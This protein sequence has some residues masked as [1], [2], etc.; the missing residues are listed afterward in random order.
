MRIGGS[1]ILALTLGDRVIHAALTEAR[2]G[3]RIVRKLARFEAPTPLLDRPEMTG[4]ALAQFLT[5]HQIHAGRTIVGVPARWVIAQERDLPPTAPAEA[6]SILRLQAERMAQTDAGTLVVD[7]AGDIQPG[8]QKVLLVGMLRRQVE[9]IEKLASSAKL[10]LVAICPTSLAASS[11]LETDHNMLRLGDGGAELVQWQNGAARALRPLASTDPAQVAGEL[12]RILAMR[13]SAGQVRLADELGLDDQQTRHLTGQLGAAMV[14]EQEFNVRIDPSAMNGSASRFQRSGHL[15]TVAVGLAGLDLKRLPVNFLDSRLAAEAPS[16]LG[17]N[18]YAAIAI[19]VLL[20]ALTVLLYF[21]T[22]SREQEAVMLAD[23]LKKMAPDVAAAQTRLDQ[24]KVGR[25][26]FE[27]RAAYLDCLRTLTLAFNYDEPI[28]ATSINLR[29]D[30]VGTVQGSTTNQQLALALRDRLM[31]QK[32][33]ANV[34]LLDLREAGGRG[35]EI[36]WSISFLFKPE[37]VQK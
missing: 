31:N 8:A 24:F 37:E 21:A 11:L 13:G 14:S 27:N 10:D 28:W 9:L 7:C 32:A 36:S 5:Q 12:R 18:A 30:N 35:G 19:G 3:E 4:H 34:Q 29:G 6:R 15:P 23:Q 25:A 20:V 17:R 16:R 26:Y 2:G 22:G 33:F 1:A